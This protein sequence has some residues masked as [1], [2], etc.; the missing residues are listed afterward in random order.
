[1]G[2]WQG[3]FSGVVLSALSKQVIDFEEKQTETPPRGVSRVVT[4]LAM[5]DFCCQL[6]D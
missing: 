1:M 4:F 2:E 6:G 3:V 5:N